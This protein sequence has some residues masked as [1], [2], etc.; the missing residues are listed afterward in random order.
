[1]SEYRLCY[2][3]AKP[4][5]TESQAIRTRYHQAVL[6]AAELYMSI[7]PEV[8]WAVWGANMSDAMALMFAAQD[9][10]K[11]AAYLHRA[12]HFGRLCVDLFLDEKSPLPKITSHDDF[13]EIE[14][15][16]GKTTDAWILDLLE[17]RKRLDLLD[18]GARRPARIVTGRDLTALSK[19]SVAGA[20]AAAWREGMKRALAENRAGVW[21]CT[22]LSKPAASVSLAYGKNGERSLFLSRRTEG[23]SCSDG[24]PVDQLELIASDFINTIPTLAEAKPFNGR[25][26]RRFSGKHREVSTATYGGFKDVLDRAGLLLANRGKKAAKVTV[27]ATLHDSWDDRD[28]KDHTCTL[29]P[30]E[31]VLVAFA[32]GEK[33]FIRRL[34]LRSDTANAVKLEQFAF[35]MTPR[36]TLNPLAPESSQASQ[37]PRSPDASQPPKGPPFGNAQPKLVTDGL[38]LHLA[39]DS[40]KSLPDGSTVGRWDSQVAPKLVALADG[41]HRPALAR[42]GGRTVLRFDGKDDFLSIAD[43]DVL[44]LKAW[45]L[46]VVARAKRGPGVVLGKVDGRNAVMNYRLQ[47]EKDGSVGAVVRGQSAKHQVNRLASQKT[48]NRFAVIAAR[49]NPTLSGTKRI[50]IRVDGAGATAYSYE[51]A[52]GALTALT[53]DRPLE[54][55]RQPGAEPRYLKGDIAEI[56]LYNRSLSDAEQNSA[57]RWLFER[58][59]GTGTKANA[60]KAKATAPAAQALVFLIAGQSNAGGVAA[61]SPESN[62]KSGMA[63]KHPTIPG[64]TAREVGIP[65]ASDAYP[66]SYI[67]TPGKSFAPLTPGKNLWNGYPQDPNRHGIELPVAMQLEKR[68]PQ[69]DTFFVK[70]GPGGHNLHTQWAAGRGPDYVAFM[71]YYRGAMLDLKKRYNKVRVIGLYWDQ[72]ESDRPKAQD[73]GKNLRALFAAFRKDTGMPNLQIFVRKHLF[74]HGDDSFK[75]ILDAQVVVAKEDRNTHLL[76]LDLGSNEKNFKAWAWTDRNG[77]L[78]SKAYLELTHRILDKL[79]PRPHR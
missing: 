72:G 61:L 50:S 20:K 74:Q 19:V 55:G 33:R 56:L 47:I 18:A 13:Y 37:G 5:R 41:D 15:V 4:K 64:S 42:Q 66:R 73:Y 52:E 17:L 67:W 25:Y 7:N 43:H 71:K 78:S 28:T 76:D 34:D 3:C 31:R 77:H 11:N 75:P 38:V 53:H 57:A 27:T 14:R 58:R 26:R 51:N 69:A 29:Q 70:H 32:A 48:L 44:D 68:Y 46:I 63:K 21:D 54:I 22:R 45:T 16:T 62:V 8:Q 79:L 49:F 2:F 39:G 24:L 30:G 40:L 9:L 6:D 65:T 12:D 59:P 23:F 10:T 36:S 60:V 35:A 1:M